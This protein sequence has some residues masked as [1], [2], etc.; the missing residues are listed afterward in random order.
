M[1]YDA[2]DDDPPIIRIPSTSPH[3]SPVRNRP[4]RSPLRS[5]HRQNR[6]KTVNVQRSP[7]LAREDV[8]APKR[9]TTPTLALGKE[10]VENLYSPISTG[11]SLS[12]PFV[13]PGSELS[14]AQRNSVMMAIQQQL[15]WNV[16]SLN[17]GVSVDRVLKWWMRASA[18]MIRRG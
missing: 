15:D 4:Q 16:I 3:T 8:S 11:R 18:E 17:S 10:D 13:D 7:P 14:L 2:E 12:T 6:T 1:N 9:S 5:P